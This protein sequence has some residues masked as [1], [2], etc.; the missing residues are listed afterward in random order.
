MRMNGDILSV[1]LAV[2]A[3]KNFKYA[4]T[5]ARHITLGDLYD[6]MWKYYCSL[7][8]PDGMKKSHQHFN[9]VYQIMGDWKLVDQ[10]LSCEEEELSNYYFYRSDLK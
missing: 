2:K 9:Y 3:Y 7:P 1:I 5:V 10:L 6:D 8:L 4:D